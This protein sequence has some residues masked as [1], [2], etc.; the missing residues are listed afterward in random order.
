MSN[1]GNQASGKKKAPDEL[2]TE[3]LDQVSGGLGGD[4]IGVPLATGKGGP[5][6]YQSSGHSGDIAPK[7][8]PNDIRGN[9]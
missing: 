2:K 7:I 6:G 4:E 1:D 8:S 5:L 3:E 9:K